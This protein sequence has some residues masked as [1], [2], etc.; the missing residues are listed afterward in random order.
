VV[1]GIVV[2][3]L[4]VVL[5]VP[6]VARAIPVPCEIAMETGKFLDWV[7]CAVYIEM[8]GLGEGDWF[9]NTHYGGG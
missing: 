4:V 7:L 3:L 6:V 8:F 2:A 9:G 5:V 1:R